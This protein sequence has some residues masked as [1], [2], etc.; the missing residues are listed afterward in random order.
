MNETT[1]NATAV[2]DAPTTAA[3]VEAPTSTAESAVAEPAMR[4]G[5]TDQIN[6]R[7]AFCVEVTSAGLAVHTVFAADD[8]RTLAMPAVFPDLHYALEQIDALRRLVTDRFAQA[9]L[10]GAQVIAQQRAKAAQTAAP[11]A[12]T[13][14]LSAT[15]AQD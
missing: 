3:V 11:A 14:A 2:A 13:T 6:G 10:V 15:P 4:A 1:L 12:S 9:A 7:S 8:G 5:D